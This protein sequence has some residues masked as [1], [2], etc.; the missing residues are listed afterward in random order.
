MTAIRSR[1]RFQQNLRVASRLTR[2]SFH[3][4]TTA[5]RSAL[6]KCKAAPVGPDARNAFAARRESSRRSPFAEVRGINSI[7]GSSRP[8]GATLPTRATAHSNPTRDAPQP[9]PLLRPARKHSRSLQQPRPRSHPGAAT[10]VTPSDDKQ[11]LRMF[12]K[13]RGDLLVRR[14]NLCRRCEAFEAYV[15]SCFVPFCGLLLP[16]ATFLVN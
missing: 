8:S 13:E 7:N 15:R 10:D 4:S 9:R 2:L 5:A 3:G 12:T 1:L 11:P 6:P 16:C 14:F